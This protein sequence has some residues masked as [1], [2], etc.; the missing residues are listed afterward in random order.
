[1]G[2]PD[3]KFTFARID[4]AAEL[5]PP[6]MN[7]LSPA[8]VW[9]TTRDVKSEEVMSVMKKLMASGCRTIVAGGV[10]CE[11]W[12]GCADRQYL[13]QFPTKEEQDANLVITTWHTD[14]S[15]KEVMFFF[16]N[17]TFLDADTG[18]YDFFILQF[19]EDP[20][21]ES[22]FKKAIKKYL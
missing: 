22:Q 20:A 6:V 1:M 11:R 19:G 16:V 7:G 13:V 9:N 18:F 8:L 4:S 5:E 15:P 3:R 10:E 12:H 21:I 2:Q 14:K 17:C